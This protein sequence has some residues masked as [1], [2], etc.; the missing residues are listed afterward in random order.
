MGS[1]LFAIILR[2]VFW[3]PVRPYSAPSQLLQV[4]GIN[5][6]FVPG[7]SGGPVP[8]LHRVPY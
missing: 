7:H 3:L 4:S 5:A 1:P 8:D 2:Q 6:E